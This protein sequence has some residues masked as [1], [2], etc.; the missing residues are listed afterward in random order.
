MFWYIIYTCAF[1]RLAQSVL[2]QNPS[3]STCD[4][5]SIYSDAC[6]RRSS[7]GHTYMVHIMFATWVYILIC[8]LELYVWRDDDI[9]K[10]ET[11]SRMNDQILYVICK[12][13]CT[14]ISHVRQYSIYNIY[15]NT[16]WLSD[17]MIHVLECLLPTI[18]FSNTAAPHYRRISVTL[19]VWRFLAMR[20]STDISC[21]AC[22]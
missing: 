6:F 19:I 21:A 1:Y 2:V 4:L 11:C 13:L 20:K 16:T 17:I 5:L 8:I 12:E 14:N 3:H 7:S 18:R 9:L 22:G 15:K 10:V